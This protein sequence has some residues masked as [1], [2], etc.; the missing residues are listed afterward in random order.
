MWKSSTIDDM[1]LNT[2]LSY[3]DSIW[4]Y[5]QD[6]LEHFL[7]QR[8]KQ[9]TKLTAQV[10]NNNL[11]AWFLSSI[12]LNALEQM[13]RKIFRLLQIIPTVIGKGLEKL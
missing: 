12:L 1:V 4:Y 13:E 5:N 2:S 10:T 7:S 3:R 11:R 6:T 8:S 9:S